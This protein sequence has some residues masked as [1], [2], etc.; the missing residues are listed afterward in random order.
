MLR[1]APAILADQA[2]MFDVVENQYQLLANTTQQIALADVSRVAIGFGYGNQT[3]QATTLP[4]GVA[5][6][7][8][9]INA[10]TPF[11]WVLNKDMGRLTQVAWYGT[12]TLAAPMNVIEVFLRR[13]DPEDEYVQ[14]PNGSTVG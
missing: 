9:Q 7:G 8:I 14:V 6:R 12:G 11:Q 2:G 4:S 10:Q 13:A 1:S 3:W 5:T